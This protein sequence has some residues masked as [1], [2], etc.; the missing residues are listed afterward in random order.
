MALARLPVLLV[1]S[2]S[3]MFIA[4]SF[5]GAQDA[6][7]AGYTLNRSASAVGFTITGSM[8][9]KVK[10]NGTFKDFDGSL[11]YDPA[12]PADTQMDLTV[13]TASVDTHNS[14]Q[15]Q[16]LKSGDF[17]DVEH[18]PTMHFVS[19]STATKP[20]GTFS[21]T[22]DMTIRG[23]TKRMTIPVRLRHD[24]TTGVQSS[25]IFESTFQIDRTEFG[26][27]GVPK[28]GGLKVSVSKKVDIH[29]AI[30]TNVNGPG[31][32]R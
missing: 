12:R 9:F 7:T 27:N 20:D 29:I 22:G 15:D 13:Y 16:L 23:V 18:F 14:E 30:A 25:P 6:A 32:Q 31:L 2:A 5:A 8:I 19:A 1:A 26:L 4:P 17:F 10:R 24:A 11:S 28:W 3:L 21:M